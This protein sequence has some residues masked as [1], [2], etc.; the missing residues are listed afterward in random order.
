[1]LQADFPERNQLNGNAEEQR[2]RTE[3]V[4]E[5][6]WA[7][8]R[9]G[10]PGYQLAGLEKVLEQAVVERSLHRDWTLHGLDGA[11][12]GRALGMRGATGSATVLV[13]AVLR[14]D[15]ELRSVANPQWSNY[16]P[17]WADFHFKL[18]LL[19]ALGQLRCE[20]SKRFLQDYV[21]L[22]EAAARELAPLMFEEATQALLRQEL[23]RYELIALMKSRRSAVRGAAILEC[24]DH[25]NGARRAA[26]KSAA[27]WALALP[28][29][30]N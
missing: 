1:M 2:R 10:W 12:A 23:T 20:A 21:N 4:I 28:H 22:R 3:R 16:P 30:G 7:A 14:V 26:L 17:A 24:L 25:P 9:L 13:A 5:R 18:H 6:A 19:P 11:L 29:A 27:P 8:Q 15:P